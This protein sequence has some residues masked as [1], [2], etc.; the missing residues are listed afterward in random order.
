MVRKHSYLDHRYPIGVAFIPWHQ[1]LGSMTGDEARHQN[2]VH[3]QKLEPYPTPPSP[4]HPPLLPYPTPPYPTPSHPTL[5]PPYPTHPPT[6]PHPTLPN[7]HY[8]LPPPPPPI[9]TLPYHT[10]PIPILPIPILPY[11]EHMHITK[12]VTVKLH[13][14]ATALI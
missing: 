12:T 1:T 7:P 14:H 11:F 6:T 2:L 3:L 13:C 4:T 9:P 5:P 8:T 10:L